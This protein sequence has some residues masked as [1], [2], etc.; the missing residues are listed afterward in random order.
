MN[1]KERILKS[2]RHKA[3]KINKGM[4]LSRLEIQ[5][6]ALR[7]LINEYLGDE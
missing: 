2:I 4:D 7:K 5:L 3:V 1:E 6:K